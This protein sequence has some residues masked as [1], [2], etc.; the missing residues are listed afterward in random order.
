M[1][2]W[3]G[4]KGVTREHQPHVLMFSATLVIIIG[5]EIGMG[6]WNLVEYHTYEDDTT[7]L[8]RES[9]Q[10]FVSNQSDFNIWNRV[11]T[12]LRCCG[13]EG[14]AGYHDSIPA[15]CCVLDLGPEGEHHS[16]CPGIYQRGCL[17][18]LLDYIGRQIINTLALCFFMA[19]IQVCGVFSTFAYS[20]A[21]LRE[22][23]EAR[24]SINSTVTVEDNLLNR[25]HSN[26]AG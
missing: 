26:I 4:W 22:R 5:L 9:Y 20:K 23:L 3:L 21:L 6:F 10:R 14:P 17:T 24:R 25:R 7:S 12:K 13:L 8:M 18:P 15:S 1:C 11:Q 16:S 19:L 2:L